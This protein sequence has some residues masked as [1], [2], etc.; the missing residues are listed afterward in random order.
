[1]AP[2]S[3]KPEHIQGRFY[4]AMAHQK[5]EEIAISE[6]LIAEL[7]QDPALDEQS[8]LMLDLFKQNELAA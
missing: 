3:K 7:E 6:S 1:M 8:A 4:K 2:L 5:L